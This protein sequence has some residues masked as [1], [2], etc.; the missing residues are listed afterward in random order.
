MEKEVVA[1]KSRKKLW[2]GGGVALI[3]LIIIISASS[4]SGSKN[5][6]TA[7]ATVSTSV[8]SSPTTSSQPT[9][10]TPHVGATLIVKDMK[11]NPYSVQLTQVQDPATPTDSFNAASAGKRLVAAYFTLTNKSTA[12]IQDDADLNAT[13]VGSDNQSYQANF[14]TVNGCTN[15]D[16]GQYTLTPG[17]TSSGCVVFSIPTSVKVAKVQ[18]DPTSFSGSIAQWLVP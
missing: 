10:T 16:S 3:L 1:K 18:F 9:P 17:S 2:I 13:V 7:P 6:A 14:D 11:D 8:K 15:F 12:T 4:G 5:A